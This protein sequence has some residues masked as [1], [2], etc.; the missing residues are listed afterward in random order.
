MFENCLATFKLQLKISMKNKIVFLYSLIIPVVLMFVNQRS[1]YKNMNIVYSFWAYIVVTT[2]L[3][4]FMM[5]VISLR[6]NGFLK[7]LSYMIG[8]KE[9]IVISLFLE[10]L[11]LIEIQILLFNVILSL[12][13]KPLAPIVFLYGFLVTGL[14]T[15]LGTSML[16]VL[17]LL[18]IKLQTFNTITSIF[19]LVG[20]V[21]L[22]INPSGIW[23]YISTAI[24]P[25]Q[26]VT[27][28]YLIP[29]SLSALAWG[30]L[31]LSFGYLIMGFFILKN[32]SIKSQLSR[33]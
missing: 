19:F 2:I 28:I 12:F 14:A 4:G 27:E 24:N 16:S 32:I 20:I 22:N 25:F 17:F 26:L 7:T 11:L 8:S 3:N 13:I 23:G 21:L 29:Y 15:L 1:D 31:G 33:V 30:S 6:E 18:K 10:Q 5:N 9:S